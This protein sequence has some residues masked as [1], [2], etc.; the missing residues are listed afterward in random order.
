[1]IRAGG[2]PD[3]FETVPYFQLDGYFATLTNG[4]ELG[5]LGFFDRAVVGGHEEE[6]GYVAFAQ[7]ENGLEFFVGIDIDEIDY[8]LAFGLATAFG[9]IICFDF[10]NPTLVGEEVHVVVGVGGKN[11]GD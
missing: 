3:P 8:R 5:D 2:G 11:V 6:F 9:K 10:E 1:M 7:T 4:I